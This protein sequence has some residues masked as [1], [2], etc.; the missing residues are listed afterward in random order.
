MLKKKR[1]TNYW[2]QRTRGSG[3][4]VLSLWLP[5]GE[6]LI[7]GKKLYM[8]EH[9]HDGPGRSSG[10]PCVCVAGG[11]VLEDDGETSNACLIL[12]P[13]GFWSSKEIM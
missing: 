7:N 13:E 3:A 6:P 2:R 11:E 10:E 8:A 12:A 5:L 4:S 1:V 9:T